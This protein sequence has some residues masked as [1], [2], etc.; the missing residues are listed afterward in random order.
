[1]ISKNHLSKLLKDKEG[2][3]DSGVENQKLVSRL[4]CWKVL[5]H[6]FVNDDDDG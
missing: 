6:Q 5:A 1:M 2:L 4:E 3:V